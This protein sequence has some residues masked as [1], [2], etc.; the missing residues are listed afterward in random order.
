M[1]LRGVR[2]GVPN[3]HLMVFGCRSHPSLAE[4][5]CREIGCELGGVDIFEYGNDN[6][7]VRVLENVREADVFVVQTARRPVNHMTMELLIMLDALRRASAARVT[8]VMPYFPYMRSDKKDQPRVPI[9]ARLV[10]D[11]LATSGADRVL[12]LDLHAD[13]IGGFFSIPG[14]HLTGMPLLTNYFAGLDIEDLVVVGDTGRIKAASEC[15]RRLRTPLAIIDKFRDP[16]TSDVKVRG[17]VGDV[18]GRSV[19]YVDDEVATGQSLRV[20]LR[21]IMKHK[22]RAIYGACVHPVFLQEAYE[23]IEESSLEEMVV[24]DSLPLDDERP[25]SKIRVLSVAPMLAE[26][27]RRIHTGESVSA[28][29]SDVING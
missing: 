19:L 18:C 2:M 1:V 8:A 21:E 20:S 17:L 6:T 13:Q 3:D 16:I 10:A 11:L 7:F 5:I 28:L 15:A 14:D 26:A 27:I 9:T 22:P 4:G 23:I 25:T 24:T 29:F 12:T